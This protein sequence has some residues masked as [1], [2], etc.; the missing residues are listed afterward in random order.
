MNPRR[1]L[2]KLAGKVSAFSFSVSGGNQYA[3][4]PEDV[5][6][7]LAEIKDP[8]PGLLVE[9]KW[10]GNDRAVWPLILETQKAAGHLAM[11]KGWRVPSG[12]L[13]GMTILALME[14]EVIKQVGQCATIAPVYKPGASVC[15]WCKGRGWRQ[16]GNS[17]SRRAPCY[18]CE[19]D[20]KKRWSV[21]L[22]AEMLG[23]S[24]DDWKH[25]W[26]DRYRDI[27]AIVVSWEQDALRIVK[28]R[29]R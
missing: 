16:V 10:S 26:A 13:E 28:K 7:A 19:A 2:A 21:R 18:A 3:L 17:K 15:P 14:A 22:C 25:V 4:L 1:A 12:A 8:G 5:A 23:I 11:R 9:V 24:G 20:G 29:L 27:Y 6:Y